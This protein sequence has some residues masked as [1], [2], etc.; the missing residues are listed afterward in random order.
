M[1]DGA[2]Y[3][4]MFIDV[5]ATD[6]RQA[7]RDLRRSPGV[8]LAIVGTLSLGVGVNAAMFTVLDRLLFRQPDGVRAAAEVHRLYKVGRGQLTPIS[9]SDWFSAPELDAVRDAAN[10]VAHVAGMFSSP[11][12]LV[13][14]DGDTSRVTITMVTPGFFDV[15]GVTPQRGR[16]FAADE[17]RYGDPRYVAVLSDGLWRR[18][19]GADSTIIGRGIRV[20][21]SRDTSTYTIIGVAAPGFSGVN[22]EADGFWIPFTARGGTPE[23]RGAWWTQRG[24]WIVSLISRI[25]AATDPRSVEAR[26][27]SAVRRVNAGAGSWFDPSTRIVVAPLVEA[28]GPRFSAGSTREL[29]LATRLAGMSLVVLMLA[30]ANAVGLMLMRSLARQRELAVRVAMGISRGRIVARLAVDGAVITIFAASVAT[31]L[32]SW[33][34]GLLRPLLFSTIQWSHPAIDGRVICL[35][36]LMTALATSVSSIAPLVLATRRNVMS[37]LKAGGLGTGNPASRLRSTFLAS[38]TAICVALLAAAGLFM[39]SLHRAVTVDLG[40]DPDRLLVADASGYGNAPPLGAFAALA[41]QLASSPGVE[42]VSRSGLGGGHTVG[43]LRLQ[44]RDSIPVNQAPQF[45]F[46]DGRWAKAMGL[47]LRAGRSFTDDE[48]TS[49]TPVAMINRAM[50][51][52]F[53]PGESALG[54]CLGTSWRDCYRVVGIFEDIRY[55][56]AAAPEPYYVLP[57][58][59]ARRVQPQLLLRYSRTVTDDDVARLRTAVVAAVGPAHVSLRFVRAG[60]YVER[61]LRPWRIAAALL[62]IF[63]VVGLASAGTA[64]FGLVSFDVGRRTR[65]I[66]VRIALGATKNRVVGDVLLPSLRVIGVGIFAGIALALASGRVMASLLF[67]TSASDPV[68]LV[69]T[70]IALGVVAGIAGLVPAMRATTINPVAALQAE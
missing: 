1:V 53:W 51:E 11:F 65:E 61:Q 3:M 69:F 47:R 38:Q 35:V 23:G 60:A 30:I 55:D 68:V 19:F 10:G 57:V 56:I 54:Q 33:T 16:F 45:N 8:T 28:R 43:M 6:L 4:T 27:T 14:V 34:G 24:V 12:Q 70:A 26:L 22:V 50:A 37:L 52:K 39:Q 40:Y 25:P 13:G 7:L 20:A 31:V 2:H 36:L 29:T 17:I 5:L 42:V 46:V 32:A 18:R 21:S 48:V 44:G 59:Q 67:E 9:Y 66:G 41:T 49:S 64:V 62:S 58:L 63:A 15:L